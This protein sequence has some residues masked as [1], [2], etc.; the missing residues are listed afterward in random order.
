[1]LPGR[2][3]EIFKYETDSENEIKKIF[4]G[5]RDVVYTGALGTADN[6]AVTGAPCTIISFGNIAEYKFGAGK[7]EQTK[8]V[9]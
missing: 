7:V 4:G 9:K 8:I 6:I 5:C 2:Q 1:M 3:S